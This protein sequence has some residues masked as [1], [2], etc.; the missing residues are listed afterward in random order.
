VIAAADF[1]RT[2]LGDPA[3]AAK[4]PLR[5]GRD[6]EDMLR[7][8]ARRHPGLADEATRLADLVRDERR[9]TQTALDA[10]RGQAKDVLRRSGGG[11]HTDKAGKLEAALR[12]VARRGG[13]NAQEAAAVADQLSETRR[14]LNE[15][16][17]GVPSNYK[18]PT[19]AKPP[20]VK[21]P[22]AVGTP[23]T[24]KPPPV[25]TP[26]HVKKPPP[27]K[28]PTV[29]AP[30]NVKSSGG[31]GAGKV[32]KEVG[33][34]AAETAGKGKVFLKAAA[35]FGIAVVD[36]LIPD[37][38]DAIELMIRFAM[39]YDEARQEIRRRNLRKGFAVGWAAY[40]VVPRWD[41]AKWFARTEVS[42]DVITLVVDAVGVAESAYNEGLVRGFI[43]GEKHSRRQ[44]DR[45][46]QRAFDELVKQNRMPGR[47]EGDDTYTFGRDDVYA[48]ASVLR[49]AADKVVD[50]ADARGA[51]RIAKEAR[52][53]A[54]EQYREDYE[55]G[56]AP[57]GARWE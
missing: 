9:A 7:K 22:K 42:R 13:P 43:Y 29:D 53:R 54:A 51:E 11:G 31:G 16:I 19:T 49:P 30:T 52:A 18:A 48:F 10:L 55:S 34:A 45:A 40:L 23:H 57:A 50:E 32:A 4:D 1:L 38:T 14:R 15:I 26:A 28:P 12:R 46:R 20:T 47:Y 56:R 17:T 35:K 44:A 8:V 24:K 36:G 2:H 6:M 33:E 21:E 5:Q 27:V 25:E 39:S 37:P 3:D 41:W